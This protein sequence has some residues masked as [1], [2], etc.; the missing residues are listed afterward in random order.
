VGQIRQEINPRL[1]ILGILATCVD[2][3]LIHHQDALNTMQNQGL[4]LFPVQIGRS[5]RVAEA[6]AAGESIIT[7]DPENPQAK[8]YQE[9]AKE[10][11]QWLK[12]ERR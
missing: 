6:A 7:Y 9:L 2:N 1:Q 5:V 10:I 8:N 11:D 4:P 3:R 12:S